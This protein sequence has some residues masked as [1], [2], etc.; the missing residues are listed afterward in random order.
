MLNYVFAFKLVFKS[1]SIYNRAFENLSYMC[2]IV[3]LIYPELLI[4]E[5]G[6]TYCFR[7]V[8][9]GLSRD[10]ASYPRTAEISKIA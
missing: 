4:L 2:V 5:Y 7:N 9:I 10:A 8:K 3:F 1:Q 6:S